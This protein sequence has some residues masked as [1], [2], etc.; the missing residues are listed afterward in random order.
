V[1]AVATNPSDP[2][3][4]WLLRLLADLGANAEQTREALE[5]YSHRPA[6][7]QAQ[8]APTVPITPHNCAEPI[9][10]VSLERKNMRPKNMPKRKMPKDSMQKGCLQRHGKMWRVFLRENYS[11][12][13]GTVG[14]KQ[15]THPV[16]RIDEI[17]E[18]EA[19]QKMAQ[20]V[21]E[22][23]QRTTPPT[24]VTV[25][26][27]Y[28]GC[29]EREHVVK[30]KYSGRETYRRTFG[31][32]IIPAIGDMKMTEIT[33]GHVQQLCDLKLAEGKSTSL[34]SHITC[35]LTAMFDRAIGHRIITYNPASAI[36][37]PK[38]THAEPR[39]PTLEE[40]RALLAVQRDSDYFPTW[41]L[42]LLACCDSLNFA[43]M[44]G[45]LWPRV[46]LTDQLVLADGQNLPGYSVAIRQNFYRKE[47]GTTKSPARN[48]ILPLPM[49][50]VEALTAVRTRSQ[51]SAPDD[52]VFCEAKG[53]AIS[54]DVMLRKL[55][56]AGKQVGIPWISWHDLRRYCANALDRLGMPEED[57]QYMMGHSSAA[58]TRRYTTIPD[59]ERKRPYV[60]LIARELLAPDVTTAVT[61]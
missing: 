16:G 28:F 17:S 60:E 56:K 45:L 46:S 53:V 24:N 37:L 47:F 43:E 48:R 54:Y 9:G 34:L 50:I 33:L 6:G 49:A 42:T 20:L 55:K 57:R 5:I 51:F 26:E 10:H 12:P 25:Q 40:V 39:C 38:M 2:Y 44:A 36:T 8:P 15:V 59:I 31:P 23:N 32:H 58:M 22:I 29:F 21:V 14:R 3:L 27:F 11:R 61:R 7:R 52:L 30:Q 13:D 19:G 35:G 1:S 18:E 41:E 4:Q